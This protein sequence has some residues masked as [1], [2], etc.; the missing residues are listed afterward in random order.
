[1]TAKHFT[2][3]PISFWTRSYEDSIPGPTLRI[4][5][6][7]TLNLQL[8]NQ[9]TADQPGPWTLNTLHNPNT[10]NLHVHGMHVDPT[11]I[12]DNVMRVVGPGESALTQV[13]V[14]KDHPRGVFH[15]HPHYH[16]SVFVQMGGGMVGAIVVEDDPETLPTEYEAMQQHVLVLQDFRFLGGLASSLS[17]AARAARSK[18]DMKLTYTKRGVET[19]AAVRKLFPRVQR[20]NPTLDLPLELELDA[21]TKHDTEH[22]NRTPPVSEYHTVNGQYMPKIEIRPY[23]NRLLRLLNAGGTSVLE[24]SVPGCSL[25]LIA[26]DG[27]YMKAPRPIRSL[28]L[29][30]GS[31]SDVVINCE[32]NSATSPH[33]EFLRPLQA[34]QD[35]AT[36]AFVG[37]GADVFVGVLAFFH[38]TGSPLPMPLVTSTPPPPALYGGDDLL[39]LSA[40][41]KAA[42]DPKPFEF[43]FSM[44]GATTKDGFSYKN[45]F[46]N[47]KLFDGKSLHS[48]KLGVVQEWVIVNDRDEFGK[49][50]S[51]N[52]PFHMHTNS[53][54]I[55]AMSHGAGIDYEIGDWRDVI[56][57]PTPGNVT[58]RFR[59]VDYRATIFAHCHILGHSDAGMVSVVDIV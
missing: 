27:I 56:E 15:Y 43:V 31:R 50:T 57:V 55:V 16:G 11:G 24:L 53:F 38:I 18:I 48:M 17:D 32:P 34:V 26:S 22:P 41:D 9:L 45:Y 13:H 59:P 40:E 23:E 28:L 20:K 47:H 4:Q 1:M 6:G 52:H 21:A 36:G 51:K 46:I 44:G 39:T 14:P 49:K 58:I 2:D 7:D 35:P 25:R 10:T 29:S 42:M 30:P 37:R 8:V 5:P 19:D 54:Q 33:L 12:A 3:G